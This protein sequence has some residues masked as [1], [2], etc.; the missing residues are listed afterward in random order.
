MP[1]TAHLLGRREQLKIAPPVKPTGFGGEGVPVSDD[2]SIRV[3]SA[4]S[5]R[6]SFRTDDE[7]LQL[8]TG[9]HADLLKHEFKVLNQDNL[10]I[11]NLNSNIA[12]LALQPRVPLATVGETKETGSEKDKE[13]VTEKAKESAKD[14][15]DMITVDN[16][17]T[18]EHDVSKRKLSQNLDNFSIRLKT[19]AKNV[20][21]PQNGA[22]AQ[23]A[24][25]TYS[26]KPVTSVEQETV[27]SRSV[28]PSY[29][30][31]LLQF[32]RDKLGFGS[33]NKLTRSLKKSFNF[34][35]IEKSDKGRRMSEPTQLTA[36]EIRA[37]DQCKE[38]YMEKADEDEKVEEDGVIKLSENL[39]MCDINS[40][41]GHNFIG[42][43]Q[44]LKMFLMFT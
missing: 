8:I 31:K 15:L 34:K 39:K 33:G 29:K 30:Q 41:E 18:D 5:M 17:A 40:N 20:N 25:N 26:G 6:D 36:A 13:T 37:I 14:K 23:P 35:N 38:E 3:V 24:S 22:I 27:L 19:I 21:D 28:P 43:F 9:V 16:K 42:K 12:Q 4:I 32:S 10:I 7:D 44:V 11:S 1:Q 2:D